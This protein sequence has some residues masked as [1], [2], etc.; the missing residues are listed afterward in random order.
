M[1][2]TTRDHD[3]DSAG[4]RY[5][6]PVVSRR[7]RGVSLGVNLNPNDACNWRCVYCQVPGL[8]FG[9]GPALDLERLEEELRGLLGELG[10][11]GWMERHVPEGLRRLN[12]LAFSGNGEPTSSPD[13]ERAVARVARVRADLGLAERTELVLITNGSLVHKPTVQ[14]GLRR[15]AEAGGR[16]WFKL[17]AGTD[18]GLARINTNR[19]GLARTRSN[20]RLAAGLCP[21]WIQTL[22]LDWNGPSL[23]GAELEGY[24]ALLEELLAGGAELRGVLLYGLARESHQPEAPELAALPE[25]RMREIAERI[26]RTGLPVELSP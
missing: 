3:R 22:A 13:F 18:G 20:L 10:S 9:N 19:A 12:D 4:L 5:V 26:R 14:A 17:D 25:G 23:A 6:Y 1:S 15:L 21:T 24:C 2:L 8:T 11:P 7:A 16:V